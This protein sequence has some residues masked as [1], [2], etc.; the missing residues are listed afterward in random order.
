[1][2]ASRDDMADKPLEPIA[3]AHH[4]GQTADDRATN[5]VLVFRV[6]SA[7]P[8][9]FTRLTNAF[10]K[11]VEMHAAAVALH[12]MY[13]NFVRIHKKLR[14]TPTM[15]AGVTGKLW[16]IADVVALPDEA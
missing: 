4:C 8:K 6:H 12:S 15:A 3:G 16:E 9:R 14:V 7:A 5:T 2:W 13:Y 10:A 11:T 1:M